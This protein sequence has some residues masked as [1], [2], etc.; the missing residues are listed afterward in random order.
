MPAA[1]VLNLGLLAVTK[2]LGFFGEG[3]ALLGLN[4]N[5]PAI[6]APAG[7]SFFTF[8]GISYVADA[9]R[10]PGERD[11]ELLHGALLHIFPA[12]GDERPAHAL[13][14]LRLAAR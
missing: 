6:L 2:Y 14:R 5:L 7:V 9:R 13:F 10:D 12:R 1:A 3:L 11:A 4:V 8:K